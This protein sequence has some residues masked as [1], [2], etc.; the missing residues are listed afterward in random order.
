MA[1]IKFYLTRP[2][3][4]DETAIYFLFSYG[5]FQLLP[6]GKKEVPTIKVLYNAHNTPRRL[7]QIQR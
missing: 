1:T 5:A 3:S 6:N 2:K 7:G 4:K